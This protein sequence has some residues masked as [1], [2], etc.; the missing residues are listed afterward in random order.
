MKPET[1]SNYMSQSSSRS[2]SNTEHNRLHSKAQAMLE[3]ARCSPLFSVTS[4]LHEAKGVSLSISLIKKQDYV[5]VLIVGAHIAGLDSKGKIPH[6]KP[7][8]EGAQLVA[9]QVKAER[10]WASKQVSRRC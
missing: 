7:L 5:A 3:R 9:E 6:T 4:Y 8:L 1:V 2:V 10:V